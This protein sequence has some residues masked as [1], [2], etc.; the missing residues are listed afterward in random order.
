[1]LLHDHF[2]PELQFY[3]AMALILIHRS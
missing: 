3:L 2:G 1:M